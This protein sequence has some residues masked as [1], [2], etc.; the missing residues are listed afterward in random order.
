C[1][2]S[3]T[4]YVAASATP[5]GIPASHHGMQ[6]RQRG[7]RPMPEILPDQLRAVLADPKLKLSTTP[8][9][10]ARWCAVS[11]SEPNE[12]YTLSAVSG[13][14][15]FLSVA[16]RRTASQAGMPVPPARTIAIPA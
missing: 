16:D 6:L 15:T 4:R 5:T 13:A 8:N 9:V 7:F 3:T 2:T 12:Q 1:F 11:T 14:Q 10:V